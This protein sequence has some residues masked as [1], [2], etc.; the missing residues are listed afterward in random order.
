MKARFLALLVLLAALA[1]PPAAGGPAA[2]VGPAPIVLNMNL[3]A[4][5]MS[6]DPALGLIFDPAGITVIEQ[7]FIG[8]VDLNEETTD[9]LPELA[10]SWTISSDGTEYTFTLRSDV[11]WTDG[12]RVTAGDVRYGILRTLDPVLQASFAPLLFIIKNAEGYYAGTITDPN[13]VGVTVLDDTHLRITLE[14]PTGYALTTLSLWL[15]RPMPRW[16][17]EAWGDAWTEP[18]HIVTNGPYRLTEWVHNDHITL[19]KNPTYYKA[20]SVQI[21][22]V[23]MWMVNES[24][25]WT[26]Y[27][28]GQ[29]DTAGVPAGTPLNPIQRQE[30]QFYPSGCTHYY[31][32]TVTN[33]PFDDVRVRRAFAAAIDRMGVINAALA[34][35]RRP[36][37]TYTPP[38][39][40]G[41]VDG[42]R[43]RVGL[44]F[45]PVLA[46]QWL[47]QAGYPNGQGLPPITISYASGLVNQLTAE[48]IRD[49]WYAS[50]GVSVTL[51]SLPRGD[52]FGRLAAGELQVWPLAWCI[53]YPDANNFVNEGV[54]RHYLGDWYNESFESLV[55]QAAQEQ[56]PNIRK[57]LYK[58]V[59]EILTETD[60]VM[61]PLSFYGSFTAVKPY[62]ERTASP[63]GAADIAVWRITR[64]QGQIGTG[65]GSLTSYHQDTT[66]QIPAGAITNTIVITHTPA[67]GMPAG[68]NLYSIGHVFDL[69]AVYSATGQPAQIAPGRTYTL[70][71]HY[72]EA[73]EGPAKENTLALYRWDGSRWVKEPTSTVNTSAN[74]VTASPNR[75]GLWAVL[76]QTHR[77]Y[78]PHFLSLR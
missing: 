17:I 19:N 10:T 46:G 15:A 6:I 76:G 29:L 42:Y 73:E 3:G 31:G 57:A 13:E 45:S 14:H 56:D 50:L 35:S 74:T 68:G 41:H 64:A 11:Y 23:Q 62:L 2:A 12:H 60:A 7:L 1:L 40:F 9:P 52:F 51:E 44:P 33:P 38:G 47:A 32:F 30:V 63:L 5:P 65:G 34:G 39:I 58:Q 49:T 77:T 70:T 67:Y 26:M 28:N 22:R 53:D 20:A 4:D 24:T 55:G 21:D 59:E 61:V 48:Y 25:A 66:V 69:S 36:A 78:L 37:L 54:D 18:A 72:T 8:L 16:A 71:V 27:Q 75:F 43:E